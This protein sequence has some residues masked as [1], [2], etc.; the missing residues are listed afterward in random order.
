MGGRGV[1][2][3]D[4]HPRTACNKPHAVSMQVGLLATAVQAQ[5]GPW[6]MIWGFASIAMTVHHI[7]TPYNILQSPS[8]DRL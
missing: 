5:L 8:T 2:V 1:G 3:Q 7:K 4:I 6:S